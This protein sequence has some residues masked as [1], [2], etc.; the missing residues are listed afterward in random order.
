MGTLRNINKDYLRELTSEQLDIVIDK[1]KKG[2]YIQFKCIKPTELNL[3]K[4]EFVLGSISLLCYKSL[5]RLMRG[6]DKN[7]E[8]RFFFS[9]YPVS[10]T[11]GTELNIDIVSHDGYKTNH[12]KAINNIKVSNLKKLLFML[13]FDT[14]FYEELLE[15]NEPMPELLNIDF[16]KG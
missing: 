8:T 12:F 15:E 5:L 6:D 16:F 4:F 14:E 11:T 7:K 9:L 3:F 1:I 10:K 13:E 2:Y